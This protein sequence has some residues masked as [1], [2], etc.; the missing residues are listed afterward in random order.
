MPA[1]QAGL[2]VF[3]E[4]IVFKDRHVVVMERRSRK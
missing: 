2:E 4:P 3:S 1:T